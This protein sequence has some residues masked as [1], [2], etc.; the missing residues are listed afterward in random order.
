M[1]SSTQN[2]Q[3]WVTTILPY[4]ILGVKKK[5]KEMTKKK[6]GASRLDPLFSLDKS[7]YLSSPSRLRRL[8][9]SR[10]LR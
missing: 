7:R 8:I 10:R 5:V 2:L 4:P 6:W 3:F 1:V 9:A